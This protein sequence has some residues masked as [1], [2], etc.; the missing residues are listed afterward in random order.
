MGLEG[1]FRKAF[2]PQDGQ[3]AGTFLAKMSFGM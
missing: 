2:P 3:I 1:H